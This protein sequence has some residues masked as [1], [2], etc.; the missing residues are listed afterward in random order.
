MSDLAINSLGESGKLAEGMG[1]KQRAAFAAL[2]A[3]SSFP[4][5]AKAAGVNRATVYRWVQS[6]PQFRAAYNAW[7]EELAESSRARLLTFVDQAVD[8]IGKAL[9]RQDEKVA[10]TM[11]RDLGIMRRRGQ[12]QTDPEMVA[13]QMDHQRQREQYR[14]AESMT[15]HL[16]GKAGLS[17]AQQTQ[18]IR[19][20]GL[21]GLRRQLEEAEKEGGVKALGHEGTKE[22][23]EGQRDK[24]TEAQR[25]KV[26]EELDR[27]EVQVSGD[28]GTGEKKEVEVKSPQPTP[29]P[30]VIAGDATDATDEVPA[31]APSDAGSETAAYKSLEQQQIRQAAR[32]RAAEVW[33]ANERAT[34]P[35][36]SHDPEGQSNS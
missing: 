28:E 8:V 20:N 21:D 30:D 27:D 10:V 1:Q 6:D 4:D 33:D 36:A 35:W 32:A 19:Q 26:A 18:F 9:K 22:G 29:S 15:R 13:L 34:R 23:T 5:A 14:L 2:C 31:A 25:D 11:L 16:L 17:P 7:Q 12:G 3:G 24:G